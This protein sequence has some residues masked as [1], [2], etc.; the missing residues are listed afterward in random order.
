MAPGPVGSTSWMVA[1]LAISS[2]KLAFPEVLELCSSLWGN[3]VQLELLSICCGLSP[4]LGTPWGIQWKL[5]RRGCSQGSLVEC[6]ELLPKSPI[7]QLGGEARGSSL[8]SIAR[9]LNSWAL[10]SGRQRF[11]SCFCLLTVVWPWQ[12]TLPAHALVLHLY[13]ACHN[14]IF[15]HAVPI[16]IDS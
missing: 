7:W 2:L 13:V 1:S 11:T 5:Q 6:S 12:G 4:V 15:M 14:Y 3:S 8:H 9:G 10:P 16:N